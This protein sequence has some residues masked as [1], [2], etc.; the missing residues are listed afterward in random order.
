MPRLVPENAPR[1]SRPP[2]RPRANGWHPSGSGK[3]FDQSIAL[4]H[5]LLAER[6]DGVEVFATL[7]EVHDVR[8]LFDQCIAE[9]RQSLAKR[10]FPSTYQTLSNALVRNGHP[11]EG[12]AELE[13]ALALAPQDPILHFN[14]S[15]ILMLMGRYAE[16]WPEYESRWKH[17]RMVGRNRAIQPPPLAGEPLNGKRI[18]APRRARHGRHAVF[19]PVHSARRPARRQGRGLLPGCHAVAGPGN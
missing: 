15:I 7:G 4:C 1:I 5:E 13:H 19:W 6:P 16:A 18:F 3:E 2:R 12:L 17:P 9:M 10:P 14:K 11:A 8:G